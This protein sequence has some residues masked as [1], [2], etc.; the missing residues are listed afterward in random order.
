MVTAWAT[1]AGMSKPDRIKH[2]S[3][4]ELAPPKRGRRY[5]EWMPCEQCALW[6]ATDR[7]TI[8]TRRFCSN[9]CSR[10]SAIATGRFAGDNNPRWLGGVSNDNMRYR[11]RQIEREPLKEAARRMTQVAIRSGRLLRQPCE[12]CSAEPAHAHHDD[13]TRP[14][15]VRWLCRPCHTA[16]HVAERRA[17]KAA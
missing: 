16:H 11:V 9:E 3:K 14:L 12:K 1:L 15:E 4:P 10:V 13:Y 7:D 6:F 8:G 2:E 17:T 5:Q